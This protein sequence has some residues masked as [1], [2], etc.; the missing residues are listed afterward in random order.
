M[1]IRIAVDVM[2][3]D[4]IPHAP[5]MGVKRASLLFPHV[6]F[7]LFGPQELLE[8]FLAENPDLAHKCQIMPAS[9]RVL[10]ETPARE[11]VRSLKNS[12]M[13]LAIESVRDG[14]AHGVVSSG[15]T[16]AYMALSKIIL[17]TLDGIDRPALASTLPTQ[18]GACVMLDLGAN[19]E[20]SVEHLCQFAQMGEAFSRHVLG[21]SSP[22]IGLLNIGSEDLKGHASIKEAQDIIRSQKVVGNFYGYVEGDDIM[23]GVTD[24][25][26]TDGFTGNVCLKTME[27]TFHFFMG[28]FKSHLKSSFI[29]KCGAFLARGA[30]KGIRHQLDPRYHNGAPFLGLKGVAVKSHGGTDDIGFA[31]ALGVAINMVE[32]GLNDH[33][34]E[35]VARV[36]E[37]GVWT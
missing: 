23:A 18:K 17:K 8:S 12:S 15:N 28:A 34:L 5:L 1:N 20:A 21:V 37:A 26:V 10:N 6:H 3:G 33:I 27:G 22:S 9:E 30:F 16:G 4:H 19:V 24:V 13:R 2:G 36:R 11:A 25:V 7:L 32:N 29:S 35:E 31:N 14:Q